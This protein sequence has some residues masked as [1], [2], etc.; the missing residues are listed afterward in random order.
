MMWSAKVVQFPRNM[1]VNKSVEVYRRAWLSSNNFFREGA[2][3]TVMLIFLL[4]SDQISGG[5][6]ESQEFKAEF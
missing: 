1:H 5:V 4:F 6:E 2:K 3:S